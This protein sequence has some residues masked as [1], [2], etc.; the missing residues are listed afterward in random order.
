MRIEIIYKIISLSMCRVSQKNFLFWILSI[1]TIVSV[2]QFQM[3]FSLV[4]QNRGAIWS[5]FGWTKSNKN[6]SAPR[7][8]WNGPGIDCS[9]F[10]KCPATKSDEFLEKFQTAFDPPP[11]LI[12]GKLCCNFFYNGYD[13]IYARRYEGQIVWN[14]CTC[15]LQSVSCFDF[16]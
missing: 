10:G 3:L 1:F 8:N 6:Q 12:F 2:G 5:W 4:V 7:K 16:I 15:L 11:P 9:F 13:F 14:A